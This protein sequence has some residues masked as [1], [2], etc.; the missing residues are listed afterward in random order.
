MK[1]IYIIFALI[2]ITQMGAMQPE[3]PKSKFD[4]SPEEMAAL[5]DMI[6]EKCAQEQ[7]LS[8]EQRNQL[9]REKF[10]AMTPQKRKQENTKLSLHQ[11]LSQVEK[12]EL[13]DAQAEIKRQETIQL[14]RTYQNRINPENT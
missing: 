13:T 6:D 11:G 9:Y 14:I 5:K 1:N 2:S 12:K 3:K 8:L 10:Q 4:F 7:S